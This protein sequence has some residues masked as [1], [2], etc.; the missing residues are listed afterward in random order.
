MLA[1]RWRKVL[2]DLLNFESSGTVAEIL[3]KEGDTVRAGAPLARLDARDLSLRVE[4]AQVNLE[5]ARADYDR[6]LEG[7]TP[8]QIAAVEAEIARAR[9]QL[10]ATA[11]SV[12]PADIAAARAE[13]ES[14]RARLAA[15]LAGP[16]APEVASAQAAVDQARIGLQQQRDAL[17]QAR[18]NSR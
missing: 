14:A 17:S 11:G 6:L 4:Q 18:V 1:P 7:A 9:G 8:E 2:G 13:L 16:K 3:I 10:Q 12:T 15:L 5:Q